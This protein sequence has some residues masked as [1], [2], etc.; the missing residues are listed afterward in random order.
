MVGRCTSG[1][2]GWRVGKSLALAMVRPDL[3][4]IDQEL[5]VT[6]LGKN[7]RATIVPESP[8]DPENVS[9]RS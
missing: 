3:G 9:L 7:H 2:Y 5:D 6:I 1:A 4:A 8:Y